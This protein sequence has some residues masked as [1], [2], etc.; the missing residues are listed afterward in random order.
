M[1]LIDTCLAGCATS[2]AGQTRA[3][4]SQEITGY[5]ALLNLT[6]SYE[7]TTSRLI[8]INL[9]ERRADDSNKAAA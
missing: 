3:Q 8:S 9:T 6:R 7:R 1:I 2:R 5:R 4:L